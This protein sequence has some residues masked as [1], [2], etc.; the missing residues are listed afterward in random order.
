M[1]TERPYNSARCPLRPRVRPHAPALPPPA[2]SSSLEMV[3]RMFVRLGMSDSALLCLLF[4]CYP[5]AGGVVL[6]SQFVWGYI[7]LI[8]PTISLAL[9]PTRSACFEL[10]RLQVCVEI[11][12]VDS[13]QACHLAR[14]R[15]SV[16]VLT[17][18]HS[19]REDVQEACIMGIHLGMSMSTVVLRGQ[20]AYQDTWSLAPETSSRTTPGGIESMAVDV[21][22]CIVR[23]E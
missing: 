11:H 22:A 3:E 5:G 7:Y 4:V 9:G 15:G 8:S 18:R 13:M 23:C 6:F 19:Q 2:I 10:A 16:D 20:D 17:D 14:L 21:D 1:P 12:P